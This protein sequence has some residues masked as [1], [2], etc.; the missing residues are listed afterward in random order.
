MGVLITMGEIDKK[1]NEIGLTYDDILLKVHYSDIDPTKVNVGTQL[2]K[3]I[4]LKIPILSAAM[5]TV[6][7]G[8]M[9]IALALEGGLGVIHRNM[10]PDE[11]AKEV[12][13][14]KR[15]ESGFVEN[16][17]TLSPTK[18]LA[19][20]REINKKYSGIPITSDGS[21]NGKLVGLLTSK[22]YYFDDPDSD[23]IEN[24][25]TPFNELVI[26]YDGITLEEANKKLKESKK[27]KVLII[28]N[29]TDQRLMSIVC[30]K[31]LEK[32]YYFP[33]ACK[34]KD[35]RLRVAAAVG[36]MDYQTRVEKLVNA[37]VDAVVIDTAH[38]HSKNVID[39][40]KA[41]KGS[42]PHL[43][44]IAGNVATAEGVKALIDAGADAVKVGIGP[45]AICTTRVVAG[46]GVPQATAVF[47]CVKA[48][49]D[50][51]II[52]DGGIKYSGDIAKAIGLGAAAVMIG[53]LFAGVDEAPGETYITEDHR[54]FKSYRGMGSIGAMQKGSADRYGQ[55]FEDGQITKK[56]VPEGIEGMVPAIGPLKDHIYQMIGGLR[57]AMGYCGAIDLKSFQKRAK[58]IRTISASALNESHPRVPIIKRAPN[59][60]TNEENLR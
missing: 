58:F 31:D 25:M 15:F 9:A 46:V 50:V 30:R 42:Y 35:K 52:A 28:N 24:Y 13:K 56:L 5:D 27:G 37:R 49:E 8:K 17:M 29:D 54:V 43:D 41:I 20:A 26:A 47:E 7:E 23:V 38:G 16:P 36:P 57:Q 34:D 32:N 48:A 39:T 14:V 6:T 12:E 3:N 11:E 18:T 10:T 51:G 45:G 60:P 59:Y 22:D 55:K 21:S 33:Y 1:I 53:S 44:I 4:R 40:I 2:T 19:E